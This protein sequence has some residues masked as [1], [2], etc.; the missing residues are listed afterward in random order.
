MLVEY[1]LLWLQERSWKIDFWILIIFVKFGVQ[2]RP[3]RI[4]S[5]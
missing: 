1:A 4:F 3:Q 2:P 5:L